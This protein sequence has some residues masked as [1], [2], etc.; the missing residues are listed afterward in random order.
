MPKRLAKTKART[1]Q[2][3]IAGPSGRSAQAG[4]SA[5]KPRTQTDDRHQS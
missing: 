4:P 1:K 3:I 5:N 2:Q